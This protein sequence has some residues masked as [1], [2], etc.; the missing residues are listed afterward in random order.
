M[1]ST[2]V[3]KSSHFDRLP[4]EIVS[5]IFMTI[6]ELMEKRRERFAFPFQRE[7][8]LCRRWRNIALDTHPL[9]TFIFDDS[10][11]PSQDFLDLVALKVERSGLCIL[12]VELRWDDVSAT[13]ERL[14]LVDG[15]L[16]T[17]L[18]AAERIQTLILKIPDW[19][20]FT[21]VDEH[22]PSYLP[23]LE[24]L[25]VGVYDDTAERYNILPMLICPV[26]HT[27]KVE[28]CYLNPEY[29][30]WSSPLGLDENLVVNAPTLCTLVILPHSFAHDKPQYLGQLAVIESVLR[31]IIAPSLEKLH[32]G[33]SSSEET[34]SST[35]PWNFPN[36]RTLELQTG[37]KTPRE[38]YLRLFH[39]C[40]H[41][42]H[43]RIR[44]SCDLFIL[45]VAACEP[46]TDALMQSLETLHIDTWLPRL[47]R[48]IPSLSIK[49]RRLLLPARA[50]MLD[51][52]RAR[53][54]KE[55][56]RLGKA[57][58]DL[59]EVTEVQICADDEGGE[60]EGGDMT[61]VWFR[62]WEDYVKWTE[63]QDDYSN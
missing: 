39:R 10:S 60:G 50:V 38:V 40:P 47:G 29:L 27:L 14:A 33:F 52:T 59:R 41:L 23:K 32:L 18:P 25:D 43:L 8:H 45:L 42:R 16:R 20:Y 19:T 3:T 2:L 57:L 9:W 48:L 5:S 34:W 24:A 36:L 15:F 58:N 62:S 12:Q 55:F 51:N 56:A 21:V 61:E 7:L 63:K 30:K 13:S 35:N 53:T 4:P 26:L 37:Y 54:Q 49:P 11:H 46:P 1:S 6:C 22:L 44:G 31:T 17:L 28:N